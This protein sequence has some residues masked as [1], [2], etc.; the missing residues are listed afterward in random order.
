MKK[1][2]L[3]LLTFAFSLLTF[4]S[5][6]FAKIISSPTEAVTIAA[7]EVIDDDLFIGAETVTVEGT[8][9]GDLFAAGRAVKVSGTINGDIFAFGMTVDISGKIKE[10]VRAGA[11]QVTIFGAEI[12]D[13]VAIG[14]GS[15]IVDKETK[16]GGGVVFGA[17]SMD[18]SGEVGR[19]VLGG[20]GSINIDGKVGKDVEITADSVTVSE[21]VEIGGNFTYT[22]EKEASI[23]KAAKIA[24][25]TKQRLPKAAEAAKEIKGWRK[26]FRQISL[27][28]K[29]FSYFAALLVG[30]LILYF[31]Q[32][33]SEKISSLI[34]EK[35]W[36]VL[37]TGFVTLVLTPVGALLLLM[38]GIG[39]P[40][41]AILMVF[42][43]LDLYLAKI[44]V[45]LL[46]GR[47]LVE[48]A[49]LKKFNIYATFALGLFV[50]FVITA[51]PYVGKFVSLAAL[52]FGLGSLV[53]VKRQALL[54]LRK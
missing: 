13:G 34:L 44:F 30:F 14:A 38:T 51:L 6:V 24:G 41:A 50:Y 28:V 22:S 49:D 36:Q 37:T 11:M 5:P 39:F 21:G 8:V 19:G 53:Q 10:D 32:K 40:L 18:L 33:P 1:V 20:A 25:E 46:F 4:S 27:S 3:L 31:F 26:V 29:I 2:F 52:L 47:S 43:L 23:D 54:G 16:I 45:G 12:G 7:D 15:A 48:F 42:Y 9:N 35:P 17:S